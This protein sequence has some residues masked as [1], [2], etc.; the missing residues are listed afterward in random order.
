M[1]SEMFERNKRE[2]LFLQEKK[3]KTNIHEVSKMLSINKK[4]LTYL[5]FK[6]IFKLNDLC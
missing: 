4:L 3:Y 5:S 2:S 1:R 6:D